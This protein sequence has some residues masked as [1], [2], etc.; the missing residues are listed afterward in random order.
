MFKLRYYFLIFIALISFYPT[1]CRS[2]I[3]TIHGTRHYKVFGIDFTLNNDKL[4]DNQA[5]IILRNVE[6]RYKNNELSSAMFEVWKELDDIYDGRF[7]GTIYLTIL[8]THLNTALGAFLKSGPPK[9]DKKNFP[10]FW[11]LDATQFCAIKGF[12]Y[13]IFKCGLTDKRSLEGFYVST[14]LGKGIPQFGNKE[15][16]F[17]GYGGIYSWKHGVPIDELCLKGFYEAQ[18]WA[19]DEKIVKKALESVSKRSASNL[20][21]LF[22]HVYKRVPDNDPIFVDGIWDKLLLKTISTTSLIEK[23][24]G[25]RVFMSVGQRIAISLYPLLSTEV[26]RGKYLEQCKSLGISVLEIENSRNKKLF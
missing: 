11:N 1:I 8:K 18:D 20:Y 19:R 5:Q 16:W 12:L 21:D 24:Y 22:H 26:G 13:T 4:E 23:S 3:Y 7:Q 2:E 15:I 25:K 6:E 17:T 14:F 9:I 10:E